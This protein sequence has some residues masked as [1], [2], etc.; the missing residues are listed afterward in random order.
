V[1]YEMHKFTNPT[2]YF[3]ITPTEKIIYN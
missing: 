3:E 2:F 1:K